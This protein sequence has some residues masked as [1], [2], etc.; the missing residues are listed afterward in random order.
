MR[1]ILMLPF[2]LVLSAPVAAINRCESNGKVSYSDAP[3]H[4]GKAVKFEAP[5]GSQSSSA[6]TAAARQQA[7]REKNTLTRIEKDRQRREAQEEKERQKFARADAIQKKKCKDLALRQK[8]AE[9]DAAVA[10]GKL[11]EKAKRNARRKAEK[12]QAE[13]GK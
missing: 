9:E 13:C 12:F 3:C 7:I 5:A 2:L 6:D 1:T 10:T 4:D 8:W 11:A